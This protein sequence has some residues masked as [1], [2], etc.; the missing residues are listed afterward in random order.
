MGGIIVHRC[1]GCGGLLNRAHRVGYGAKCR[2]NG[3]PVQK[4]Y[5]NKAGD[6]IE[7]LYSTEPVRAPVAPD[8]LRV[9]EAVALL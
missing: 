9:M 1:P 2:T 7:V 6:I 5:L 3:C 4:V 8:Q